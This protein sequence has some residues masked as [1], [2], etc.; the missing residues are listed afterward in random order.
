M[1][2]HRQSLLQDSN[3]LSSAIMAFYPQYNKDI[4]YL[5]NYLKQKTVFIAKNDN[6]IVECP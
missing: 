4:P 6:A 1:Q 5:T 3:Q 2:H